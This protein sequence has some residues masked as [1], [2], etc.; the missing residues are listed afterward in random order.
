MK[1]CLALCLDQYDDAED[2]AQNAN[3]AYPRYHDLLQDVADPVPP[4]VGLTPSLAQVSNIV[5]AII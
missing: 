1:C 4:V 5:S 2:V 3:T